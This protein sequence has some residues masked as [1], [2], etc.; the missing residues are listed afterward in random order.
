MKNKGLALKSDKTEQDVELR[1]PRLITLGLGS[2]ESHALS[3]KQYDMLLSPI[4]S[5]LGDKG[6]DEIQLYLDANNSELLFSEMLIS[7]NAL[8]KYN[9]NLQSF[10]LSCVDEKTYN[11]ITAL[12][13]INNKIYKLSQ[14]LEQG[15]GFCS[16]FV[17][18]KRIVLGFLLRHDLRKRL[19]LIEAIESS[20]ALA[21]KTA[22][23]MQWCNAFNTVIEQNCI[24]DT[25]L[26]L[27]KKKNLKGSSGLMPEI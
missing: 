5:Y 25:V 9:I 11:K 2:Y 6:E 7:W 12:F 16:L 8:E 17:K 14:V 20:V 21:E 15:M 26:K 10:I 13:E 3:L 4:L 19:R 23:W 1:S 27:V 18:I 22:T 24:M